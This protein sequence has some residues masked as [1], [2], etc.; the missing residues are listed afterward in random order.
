MPYKA[1]R[2]LE[3][4]WGRGLGTTGLLVGAAGL[5]EAQAG[6]EAACRHPAVAPMVA[7]TQVT[8]Y[9]QESVSKSG[10]NS[11][12]LWLAFDFCWIPV[13]LSCRGRDGS[14]TKWLCCPSA[15]ARHAVPGASLRS[16]RSEGALGRGQASSRL[17]AIHRPCKILAAGCWVRRE[18]TVPCCPHELLSVLV[19]K[20]LS[21]KPTANPER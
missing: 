9:L 11:P 4:C 6:R 13:C 8:D 3:F 1:L 14:A 15:R 2:G 12:A 10:L 20:D 16:I 19:H 5:G 17:S 7:V 18:R 21:E